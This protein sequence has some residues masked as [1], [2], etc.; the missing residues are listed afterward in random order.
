[1]LVQLQSVNIHLLATS[2]QCSYRP[3]LTASCM[4]SQ[5]STESSVTLLCT[6]QN[7]QQLAETERTIMR[8]KLVLQQLSAYEDECVMYKNVGKAYVCTP[9]KNI[10]E[11]F[12]ADFKT[13]VDA[14]E[15]HKATKKRLED[16]V[17][18]AE[19]EFK[20]L[21]NSNPAVGRAFLQ[22]GGGM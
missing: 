3:I 17:K 6:V 22:S 1:V 14:L 7:R 2:E 19:N 21:L 15:K 18:S 13:Y 9:K 11:N 12:D 8:T 10:I 4:H 16:N 20:E 5:I